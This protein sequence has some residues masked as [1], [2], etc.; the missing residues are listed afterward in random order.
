MSKLIILITDGED[1]TGQALQAAKEA[2]EVGV[3]VFTIGIGKEIGAPLPNPGKTGGF[4]KNEE[5]QVI[6][7]KLDE[8]TL[9]KISL[10]TGGSYVRSVTGDIDLKTIYLDQINQNLEKK[11]FKS[12]RRKIWQERFQWFI[13]IALLFLLFEANLGARKRET[14]S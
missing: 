2:R 12:E 10:E 3:K 8:T 14:N 11:K 6:L 9:Q 7:T 5:G 4:L 13:F 1:Q